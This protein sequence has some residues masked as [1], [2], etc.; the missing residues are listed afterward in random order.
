MAKID[1]PNIT[2]IAVTSVKIPETV[3]ALLASMEGINFGEVKLVSHEQIPNLPENIKLELAPKIVTSN[4]Y[5]TFIFLELHKYIN[6][7]YCLII[8][9]DGWVSSPEKWEDSW[10]TYDYI[11]APWRVNLLPGRDICPVTG[12]VIRVGNGGFSLRSKKI[13]KIPSDNNL[14]LLSVYNSYNED[15]NFCFLHRKKFLDL[16]IKYAPIDVAARFSHEADTPEI[17]GI[18]PFGFHSGIIHNREKLKPSKWT[19]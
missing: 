12:E 6:T 7:D 8:Q 3:H 17:H 16:G 18:T 10:M 15:L 9:H 2:L 11:G 13:L 1:L 14:P 4:Q 5:S 19:V